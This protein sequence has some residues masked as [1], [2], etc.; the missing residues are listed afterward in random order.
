VAGQA[1][2]QIFGLQDLHAALV[3][4]ADELKMLEIPARGFFP[5]LVRIGA[6]NINSADWSGVHG[7]VFCHWR[8][9]SG[10]TSMIPDME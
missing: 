4:A 8:E 2:L 1:E 9:Q 10:Y 5:K 6:D 3:P 7:G